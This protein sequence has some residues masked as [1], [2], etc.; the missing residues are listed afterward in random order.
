MNALT[1]ERVLKA[2]AEMGY[3]YNPLAG[4]VMSEIRRSSVTNFRGTVAVV[5]FESPRD[6]LQVAIA[7]HQLV[8]E[9]AESSARRLGYKVDF[10][11]APESKLSI[12]R[13]GDILE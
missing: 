1:R 5:D 7:Y 13:L 10:F 11:N 9:G 2:A 4:S 3:V 12:N 8:K 6:R